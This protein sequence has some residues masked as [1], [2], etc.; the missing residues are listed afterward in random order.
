[1]LGWKK[2]LM[3]IYISCL[4]IFISICYFIIFAGLNADMQI[5]QPFKLFIAIP[6]LS[7]SFILYRKQAVWQFV[8]LAASAF[9]YGT[10][11]TGIGTFITKTWLSA[12]NSLL[13]E[14]AFTLVVA[15]FTL[16]PLLFMLKRLCTNTFMKK[17]ITFWR[18]FWLL[19]VFFF[20]ITMMTNTYLNEKDS[21]KGM[22]FVIIRIVLY[23]ALLLICIL[24]EKAVNQIS[25]A[26]IA[27]ENE[28]LALQRAEAAERDLE[29][30]KQLAASIPPESLII[31]GAFTLN[32]A[33]RQ[34]FFKDTDLQL[35][36]KEFELLTYFIE[37]EN[38]TI[39]SDEIFSEVWK[40]PYNKT[41]HALKGALQRLRKKIQNSGYEVAT[42]YGKGYS[43]KKEKTP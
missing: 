7:V 39:A 6:T 10:V 37:H 21:D 30:Q 5:L 38:E 36:D 4:A 34:A 33:K 25:E 18:Y 11:N 22:E 35:A 20:T 2:R 1:V 9:V 27:R 8:F 31:C 43:F 40:Q 41:D 26:E 23:F 17:A 13:I 19:P 29:L 16:P 32:T 42:V 12:D 28:R 15:V 3:F 24:L 14:S